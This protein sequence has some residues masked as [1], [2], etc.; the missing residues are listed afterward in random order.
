MKQKAIFSTLFCD[1]LL[2]LFVLGVILALISSLAGADQPKTG[3]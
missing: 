2:K 1:Q 3:Y